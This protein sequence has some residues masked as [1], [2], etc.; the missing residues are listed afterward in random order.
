[1]KDFLFEKR[2]NIMM[3]TTTTTTKYEMYFRR[4]RMVINKANG[5]AK[6]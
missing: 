5:A 4:M 3:V 6:S 1:M 2:R